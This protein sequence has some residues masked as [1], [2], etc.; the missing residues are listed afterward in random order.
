[1]TRDDRPERFT[2]PQNGFRFAQI[3]SGHRHAAGEPAHHPRENAAERH[4][5]RGFAVAVQLVREQHDADPE[6]GFGCGRQ[7]VRVRRRAVHP[8]NGAAE[9]QDRVREEPERSEDHGKRAA[10]RRAHPRQARQV[11]DH[12]RGAADAVRDPPLR[13]GNH[14][15]RCS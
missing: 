7:R 5:I 15:A 14:F 2:F 6:C 11:A 13:P 8:P 10:V 1:M 9:D 4:S 12:R 3:N